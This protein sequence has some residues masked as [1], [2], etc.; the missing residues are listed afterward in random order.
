[1]C[2]QP[3]T[4]SRLKQVKH[5]TTSFFTTNSMGDEALVCHTVTVSRDDEYGLQ[6]SCEISV[7]CRLTRGRGSKWRNPLSRRQ[8]DFD[9]QA[10]TRN[11]F[12]QDIASQHFD[13]PANDGQTD[14]E[15]IR[16]MAFRS[17]FGGPV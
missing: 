16:S 12:G 4:E 3:E 7:I 13:R 9:S 8:D 2:E 11:V 14:A 10:G 6:G 17:S 15:M 5:T 1:M